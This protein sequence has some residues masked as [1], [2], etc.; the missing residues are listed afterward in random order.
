MAKRQSNRPEVKIRE[1]P[2][3]VIDK[4][5]EVRIL[6]PFCDPPHPISI[7]K[8]SPCGTQLK[9]T[10]VQALIPAR[11]VHKYD[12]KCAK[13]HQGGGEMIQF[14][15]GYVHLHECSPGTKL[16]TEA[17]AF[18]K[19]AKYIYKLPERL[20][21]PIERYTGSARMV[22]EVDPQGNDTGVVLGY[23]FYK[24][25]GSHAADR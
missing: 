21:T 10:A 13:C 2:P 23:F 24:N 6:C 17:P 7:G 19:A 16:M 1:L 12:L 8:P 14:H 11:T 9:L 25:G 5:D 20:R 3:R 22:R 18:S 4:K 15:Q